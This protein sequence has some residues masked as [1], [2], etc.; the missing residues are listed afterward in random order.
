MKNT[1]RKIFRVLLYV[2]GS[3]IALFA[4]LL[5]IIRINSSG[6]AEPVKNANGDTPPNSIAII[7]DTVINGM[8]Q[9]LTIRGHDRSNPVLLRVHGGPGKLEPPQAYRATNIDLE[10]FFTVCYW[11]Q[12]GVGPAFDPSIDDPKYT[13]EQIVQDGL[14]V[15]AF[16]K[17]E[18]NQPKIYIEGTSTG[19]VIAPLMVREKPDFYTA[20]IG[21]AQPVDGKANEKLSYDF[22][23]AEATR[24]DD[25]L[26][27]KELR[28]IGPPPYKSIEQ[29]ND[30]VQVER[31]YADKYSPKQPPILGTMDIMKLMFLY[32]GWSMGYKFSLMSNG[33][34]SESTPVLWPQFASIN[35]MDEIKEYPVPIYIMH[36][37]EDHFTEFSLSKMYFD[38]LVAPKKRFYTF[39]N[40]GHAI[41]YDR[42]EKYR[43][44]YLE[45][46]LKK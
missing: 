3:V 20:Y 35:M 28:R 32:D 34:Y 13:I 29:G 15:T 26:A 33:M 25:T 18:F 46:I 11:D 38:S 14:V 10:E 42:P 44:I 39:K 45:E 22:V 12:R 30:A 5:I 37:E 1:I 24:R 21:V 19:A 40:T 4:V 23:L 17:E 16:L 27:L 43:E 6:K 7:K 31:F 41:H 36:G 9:R 8:A 2:I